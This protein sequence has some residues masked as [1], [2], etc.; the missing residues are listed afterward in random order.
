LGRLLDQYATIAGGWFLERRCNT[1]SPELKREFEWN[2]G[3][4]NIALSQKVKPS[5]LQGLQPPAEKVADQYACDDTA[6]SLVSQ[7]LALSRTTT[8][9][10]TGKR[11]SALEQ[12]QY[13]AQRISLLLMAKAV[14]DRCHL[15]PQNVRTAFDDRVQKIADRFATTAGAQ[16]LEEART[17]IRGIDSSRLDCT[18]DIER[19]LRNTVADAMGK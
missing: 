9:E 15:I 18:G 13:D 2:V 17:K 6:R 19:W 7:V 14:D 16:A 10:L 12:K 11:Y 5:F 3:Q 8:F 4:T 1:L